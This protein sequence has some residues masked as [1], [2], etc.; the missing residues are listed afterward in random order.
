MWSGDPRAARAGASTPTSARLPHLRRHG[1]PGPGLLP[2]QRRHHL[3]RRPHRGD[4]GPPDGGTWRNITTEE[5]SK[6]AETLAEFRGQ[7]RATT[8]STRTWRR[9]NARVPSI[10]PVGRPRGAQQLVPGRGDRRHDA[11]DRAT[12]KSVDGRGSPAPRRGVRRVPPDLDPRPGAREP[13]R[14]VRCASG[15]SAV[16]VLR[17]GHAGSYRNANS[18]GE[19]ERGPAGHPAAAEQLEWLKRELAAVGRAGVEGHR[20]GHADL[21]SSCRTSLL[22]LLLI[23]GAPR[24]GRAPRRTWG[25]SCRSRRC[26]VASSATA[27]SPECVADGRRA[28]RLGPALTSLR[29]PAFGIFEPFWGSVSGPLNAGAFPAMRWSAPSVPNG[30]WRNAPTASNVPCRRAASRLFFGEVDI[31]GDSAET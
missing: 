4:G 22:L 1:R 5:K 25:A 12:E 15:R 3:R 20:G 29:G 18:P 23:E 28:P 11:I 14:R 7:L 17:A 26:L 10:D 24:A 8:C 6:V 30:S 13:A 27:G 19:Q 16:D 31:D 21:A 9:F 2:V